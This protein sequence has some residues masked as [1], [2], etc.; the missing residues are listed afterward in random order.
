MPGAPEAA[1]D[2]P[3][4]KNSHSHRVWLTEPVQAILAELDDEDGQT[5]FVFSAA[6][7]EGAVGV[8][9]L[10]KAKRPIWAKLKVERAT[11]P[12]LR[13]SCLTTVTGLG[14]SRD[15]MDRIATIF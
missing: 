9:A 2:W 6:R 13:R 11:P 12:D 1:T 15:D 8:L 3:G 7:G 14:F 4:T 10:Q 5:G